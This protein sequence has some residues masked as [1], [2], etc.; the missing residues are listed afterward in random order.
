MNN[1][2]LIIGD[3]TGKRVKIFMSCLEKY[4]NLKYSVEF[5]DW[6]EVLEDI[7]ILEK[8]F[9]HNN[10]LRVEPPEKNMQIYKKFLEAGINEF[11]ELPKDTEK[12]LDRDNIIL[13]PKIWFEGVKNTFQ[14]ISNLLINY[15]NITSMC[16]FE[17]AL[18][19]MDKEKTYDYLSEKEGDFYLPE[20]IKNITNYDEFF[21]GNKN[22]AVKYFIKLRCGSGSTGVLAYSY[23][24]KLDE[25]KILT[26]LD[27]KEENNRKYFFSTFQVKVYTDK[28]VIKD[29]INWVIENGA[30]IEKWVPKLTYEG[31]AYD[32]RVFVLDKKPEY[33]LS[34]LSTTPI[35]NLHLKNKRKESIEFLDSN[36]M[37]LLR[38][39]SGSV[40]NIFDKSLYAG[41]DIVLANNFKPY[42]I[43]INPFGDLFHNL[44][45]TNK[46]VYYLEIE[47]VLEKI[48]K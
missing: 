32:T 37:E 26:S 17:E 21:Q 22:K 1:N 43:D 42:V 7:S 34:R 24:P 31:C 39:A 47:K 25:E 2:Y 30:H 15:K 6:T 8:A 29:M 16:N 40:M 35:T 48:S 27:Y 9:E 4:R 19:M 41:I 46:N 13:E 44:V 23:N 14:N 45:N 28:K 5:L 36:A 12:M 33:F 20:R 38:K 10:I 11:R 18:I 3:K